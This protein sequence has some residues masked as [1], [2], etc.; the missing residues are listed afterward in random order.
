MRCPCVAR[1]CIFEG[2]Q[3][4]SVYLRFP[5]MDLHDCDELDHYRRY[6]VDKHIVYDYEIDKCDK[7]C[8]ESG[9]VDCI[10]EYGDKKI[11][12]EFKGAC[13]EVCG[14]L[15]A[16]RSGC[17]VSTDNVAL[18]MVGSQDVLRR[19]E[20]CGVKSVVV[21]RLRD[22]CDERN[23]LCKGGIFLAAL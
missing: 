15:G 23:K 13:E 18:I 21:I 11:G 5:C 20:E 3:T 19:L 14:L 1:I 4:K 6:I 2:R 7:C 12:V 16:K 8:R 17:G 10:L 9:L 22:L